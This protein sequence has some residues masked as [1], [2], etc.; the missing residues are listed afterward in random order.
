MSA[1]AIYELPFGKGKR[2]G[3]DNKVV[4]EVIGGWEVSP[5]ISFRTG[6]PLPVYNAADESGTFSRGSRAD[7]SSLPAVTKN[8]IAGTNGIQWF[9]NNLNFTTPAVG[10]FGNC[11]PQLGGLRGPHFTDVDLSLHKDFLLTERF[12]LQFRA[13]FINAFNH[14]QLNAPD[15]NLGSTMGQITTAQ[16]P[17]NIQLALKLYY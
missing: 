17:R 13:D 14:V 6:F 12:R 5:I 1:Y 7:C 15:M 4:N 8:P 9:T 11:A 10:T 3:G 2:F 16:P